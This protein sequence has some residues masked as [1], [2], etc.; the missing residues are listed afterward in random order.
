MKT[1]SLTIAILML[2][3]TP[4]HANRGR[5]IKGVLVA[6]GVGAAAASDEKVDQVNRHFEERKDDLRA[7][8][9]APNVSAQ[10]EFSL[11]LDSSADHVYPNVSKQERLRPP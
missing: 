5:I 7:A 6:L 9:Y 4:A 2:I 1:L 3:G 8:G 10:F 11:N